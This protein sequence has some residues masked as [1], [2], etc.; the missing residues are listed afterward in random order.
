ICIAV[1]TEGTFRY[2]AAEGTAMLAPGAILLGN[3]RT[4]FECGHEHGVG[5]RC[6]SFHYT[7]ALMESVLAEV[8]GARCVDFGASPLPPSL[9]FDGLVAAAEAAREAG[10][11]AELEEIA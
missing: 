5:D 7:P 10:D 4:C 6:V 2:R 11:A 1:V 9:K 8:P 3:A